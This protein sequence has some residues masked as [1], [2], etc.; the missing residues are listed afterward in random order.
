MQNEAKALKGRYN[1]R[2]FQAKDIVERYPFCFV[3]DINL[4]KKGDM[5]SINIEA[6]RFL[7]NMVRNIVGTL[8]EIGRGY[9]KA[10][11]IKSILAKKNRAF[12]G[13]TAPALGLALVKVKY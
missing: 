13:P 1:F 11:S 8:L 6:D 9:F 2:S 4:S 5:I 3:K 10:G 12:A 7:Y